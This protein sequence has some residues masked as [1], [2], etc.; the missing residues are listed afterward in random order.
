MATNNSARPA[1]FVLA[2]M[3][4]FAGLVF[5]G[6]TCGAPEDPES[7]RLTFTSPEGK[8]V[9]YHGWYRMGDAPGVVR[10][11]GQTP[12]ERNFVLDRDIQLTGMFGKDTWESLDW[13]VFRL[14][15]D[16]TLRWCD[17]VCFPSPETL[18]FSY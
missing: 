14:Y 18:T 2:A 1:W 12:G 4:L 13:L 11:Q 6:F 15:A 16:D 8:A 17:S 9:H 7:I 10:M 5:P 3:A